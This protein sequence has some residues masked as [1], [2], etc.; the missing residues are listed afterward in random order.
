M[1]QRGDKQ[2]N[3]ELR[4]LPKITLP[5]SEPTF[6]YLLMSVFH[7]L[8]E[9]ALLCLRNKLLCF[10]KIAIPQWRAPAT[11]SKFAVVP[12][13]EKPARNEESCFA[14]IRCKFVLRQPSRS[15]IAIQLCTVID[16]RFRC[17]AHQ[18]GANVVF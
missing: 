11:L 13:P 8:S 5:T 1:A 16:S 12:E 2:V 3:A 10:C 18:S 7:S 17:Q 4:K 14:T 15:K 6:T 9:P